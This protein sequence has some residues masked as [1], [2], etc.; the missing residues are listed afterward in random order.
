[1][2]YF[3]YTFLLLY[4]TVEKNQQVFIFIKIFKYL[5]YLITILT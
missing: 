4:M 3:L 2:K 1:M 5:Y